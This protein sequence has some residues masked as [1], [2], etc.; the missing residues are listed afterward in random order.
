MGKFVDDCAVVVEHAGIVRTV[1]RQSGPYRAVTQY[2]SL[3]RATSKLALKFNFD[4]SLG[5]AVSNH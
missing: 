4:S 3:D 5:L 1:E 2:G